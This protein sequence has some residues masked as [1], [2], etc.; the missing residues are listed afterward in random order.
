MT[1]SEQQQERPLPMAIREDFTMKV[2]SSSSV[3]RLGSA[4]CNA[5]N[6]HSRVTLKMVGAGPAQQALKAWT[7]ASGWMRQKGYDVIGRPS[8]EDEPAPDG[9]IITVTKLNLEKRRI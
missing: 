2:K 1:E 8:M 4:I 9:K 5:L 6:S 3:Q 7:V